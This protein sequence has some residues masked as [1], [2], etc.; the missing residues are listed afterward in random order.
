VDGDL[1]RDFF[2][3]LEARTNGDSVLKGRQQRFAWLNDDH[4]PLGNQYFM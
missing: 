1:G 2:A 4:F 3:I